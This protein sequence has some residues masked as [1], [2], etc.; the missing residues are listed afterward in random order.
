MPPEPVNSKTINLGS[1]R[2]LWR[3]VIAG[4]ICQLVTHSGDELEACEGRLCVP[5]GE[6]VAKFLSRAANPV[7][8]VVLT[9]HEQH[10]RILPSLRDL[11]GSLDEIE[12]SGD[13]P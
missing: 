7:D 13:L 4:G 10:R 11:T 5:I 8:V 1:R 12:P 2:S 9:D 3:W 6:S